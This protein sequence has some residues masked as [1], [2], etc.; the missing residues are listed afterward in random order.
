[1]LDNITLHY[2]DTYKDAGDVIDWLYRVNEPL[3]VDCETGSVFETADKPGLQW[4][5][6]HPFVR[7]VQF[8]TATEAWSIPV[9]EWR[10]VA[11]RALQ[12]VRDRGLTVIGWNFNFDVHALENDGLAV[13][14]W[15]NIEEAM[16]YSH[17]LTPHQRNGLKPVAERHFG[18]GAT[19]GQKMLNEIMRANKW[20]WATVPVDVPEYG[21]YG[22][23]DTILTRRLW[24]ILKPQVEKAGMMPA[25]EREHATRAIMHRAERRGLLIDRPYTEQ[26]QDEWAVELVNLRLHLQGLGIE[27]PSSNRQVEAVLK[28]LGWDPEEFTD[29]GQAVL[30]KA[31]K[32]AL[33]RSHPQI[34]EPLIRYGRLTKWSSAYLRHFLS[35]G[36][37]EG[38]VHPS[39]N[40]LR[41]RTGRSSVTDPA[42]QTLPSGD[43]SVR[44]CVIA[45]EGHKLWAFDFQ[46]Q[47]PRIFAHYC[48]DPEMIAAL[49]RGEDLYTFIGRAI[50]NDPSIDKAHP[51]RDNLKVTLLAFL[52]GA[53]PEKLS[54]IT[55]R[56]EGEVVEM[57]KTLMDL[58]PGIRDL[59][60]DQALGG[61]YQGKPAMMMQKRHTEEGMSYILTA[62]GRRFAV[63]KGDERKATNGLMQ[64]S[65]GDMTKAALV[66]LD[67][68]GLADT[69]VMTVHDEFLCE[70]PDTPEAEDMAHEI[71]ELMT[72]NSLSVTV[73]AECKGSGPSWGEISKEKV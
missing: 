35:Y 31:V 2:V 25:Y 46:A 44:K 53:Y 60:G 28:D 43:M 23:M 20:N 16:F 14:E 55:G 1:M 67:M 49:N 33:V 7:L 58:F 65:A 62:G 72:D 36:D 45:N 59:T 64:G 38:R 26:L 73:P 69:V 71:Q 39:I 10:A 70:L 8:G 47:E 50:Y 27:N 66:R 30:D 63:P 11:H 48:R 24:D 21:V 17:L 57:L 5:T 52:Y 9:K 37:A 12:I 3:A 34:A 68:A 61:S 18:G 40:T 54:V 41:A 13:P 15:H 22:G 56:P 19:V 6:P 51:L 42:L 29:T 4:W 32:E